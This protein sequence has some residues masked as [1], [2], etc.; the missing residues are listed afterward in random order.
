MNRDKIVIEI[1]EQT[2]HIL[3]GCLTNLG[4]DYKKLLKEIK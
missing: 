3:I 1:D 4:L 2:Y